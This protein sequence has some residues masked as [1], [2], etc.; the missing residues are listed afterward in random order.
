MILDVCI[1]WS[2]KFKGSKDQDIKIMSEE[3]QKIEI[4]SSKDP[5][6]EMSKGQKLRS[7]V[8][9]RWN[10]AAAA[11]NFDLHTEDVLDLLC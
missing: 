8:W 1:I 10:R 7:A 11:A 9:W 4:L 6:I 5:N 3:E 2:Q